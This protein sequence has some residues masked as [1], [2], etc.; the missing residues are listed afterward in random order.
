MADARDAS[1][2]AADSDAAAAAGGSAEAAETD[3]AAE[4]KAEEAVDEEAEVKP[5]VVHVATAL[6]LNNNA[7]DTLGPVE[8]LYA[9][10]Q[11]PPCARAF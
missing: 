4:D 9:G 8:Q 5:L 6:I 3:A 2:P 1:A 7:L 10:T 11:Q